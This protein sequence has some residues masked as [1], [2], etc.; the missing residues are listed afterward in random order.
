MLTAPFKGAG[1]LF[2][3]IRLIMKPGLRRFVVVPVLINTVLFAAAIGYA[4]GQLD[5]LDTWLQSLLPDWLDWLT[6]LLWPVFVLVAMLVIFYGFTLVANVIAAP[7]NGLL[8]EKVE[9][10]LTGQP[11]ES[12]SDWKKLMKD[13]APMIFAELRKLLY[14]VLRAIPA[15]IVSIFIPFVWL[16][17]A[18]WMLA[19]EYVDYP[20]GNHGKLFPANIDVLR[21]RRMLGLGFGGMVSILTLIPVINFITVPAAVAGAT[22][23]WVEQLADRD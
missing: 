21:G 17:F 15:L 7:F 11:I 12:E 6:T 9:L 1:Y 2:R 14:F 4:S 10:L 22:A 5:L 23:M 19:V 13:L 3:G 8:S 16:I 20:L 18:A